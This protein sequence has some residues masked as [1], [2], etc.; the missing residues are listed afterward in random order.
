MLTLN[1]SLKLFLIDRQL[2]G[3][4][5]KTIINYES[6]VRYFIEYTGDIDINDITLQHLKD[7]LIHLQKREIYPEHPFIKDKTDKLSKVSV[8]SYIRQLRIFINYLYK[9]ELIDTDLC[10]K[11][12]LPKAPKKVINI[13]SDEEKQILLN[14]FTER[15]ELQIRNKTIIALMLDSGLRRNEVITLNY[16]DVNLISNYILI[17]GK[18]QKERLVPIGLTSK[19]LLIKYMKFRSLP[20]F[21]TNRLFIDKDKKPLTD[22]AIKMMF[23]RLRKKTGIDRLHPHMLRHTFATDYL[24]NGGDIFSLQQILGHSS[25]EMVRKY[26][27]LAS[28]Y[29]IANHKRLSPLDEMHKRK[30]NY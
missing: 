25:L 7:Y 22:N 29:V 24:I 1:D 19:K 30:N 4:T 14:S 5:D 3:A 13:L 9:E 15:S 23:T 16:D 6:Q 20:E 10:L 11:F 28:S 27:H 2:K 18:G 8:Q 26:S 12:R 21:Q 17:S